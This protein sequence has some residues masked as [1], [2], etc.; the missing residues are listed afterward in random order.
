MNMYE[1][2]VFFL[3]LS[4]NS[5]TKYHIYEP[6]LLWPVM[7][8]A[9]RCLLAQSCCIL[10]YAL[11]NSLLLFLLTLPLITLLVLSALLFL[12]VTTSGFSGVSTIVPPHGDYVEGMSVD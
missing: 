3:F 6:A 10:P 11:I 2:Q 8:S 1:E 9:P 4:T 7:C 12:G 5:L